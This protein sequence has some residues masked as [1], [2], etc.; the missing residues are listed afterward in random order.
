[1]ARILITGVSGL[2]GVNLAQETMTDHEI[3]GVDR[4]HLL[5]APFK[6][7]KVD[8][9]NSGVV[10]S[11]LDFVRPDWMINCAGLADLDACEE[12]PELARRLNSDLPEQMAKSCKAR[13]IPFVHISTDAVFDGKSNS[14][15]EEKD[16]P[17][18]LGV[19]ARTKLE[20]ERA[21]LAENPNA[22]VARVNF[23]G[24]SLTGK[25]SLAEFFLRNL[26]SKNNMTG[27]TDVK[28]CPMLANDTARTLVKMLK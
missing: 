14:F 27:F 18:P 19:Y 28:F 10:D 16:A 21:V 26:T 22:I 23:Y 20:S 4:G 8:L 24:W 15:Y 6:V 12:D 2:L 25:R 13:R 7:L 3:V 9:L 1:M 17:N 11:I 5:H